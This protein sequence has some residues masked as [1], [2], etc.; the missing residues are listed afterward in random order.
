MVQKGPYRGEK[1]AGMGAAKDDTH[2]PTHPQ[3]IAPK[4]SKKR[5]YLVAY[6]EKYDTKI[7]WLEPRRAEL[8]NVRAMRSRRVFLRKW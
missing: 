8:I 1:V 2:L 6:A 7:V 3:M 5:K 4:E